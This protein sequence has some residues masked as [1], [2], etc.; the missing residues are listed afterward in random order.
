M[1]LI[2][3]DVLKDGSIAAY[4]QTVSDSVKFEKIKFKFPKS[5]S[6]YT[7]TAVFKN[8]DI[9][10]NVVLDESSMLCTG[11]NECYVPHEVIKYPYF[12]VSVFGI[13]DD[14]IAT[15]ARAIIN[16]FKS[17]YELGDAPSEPT[18]TEY[19]QVI[20]IC[21]ETKNIAE[22][23][24]NDADSGIFKGEKGDTGPQGIQGIQGEKGDQGIPGPAGPQGEKGEPFTYEDFTEEQLNNLKGEK[25]DKGDKGDTGEISLDY[26]HENF[27][28]AI[29]NTVKDSSITVNDVSPMLHDLKVKVFRKNLSYIEAF[30]NCTVVNGTV[31]QTEAD[32]TPNP[33][34][35]VLKYNDDA[36]IDVIKNNI[37]LS[38][39][40]LNVQIIK[41]SGFN[42]IIF[43]INGKVSDT[44]VKMNVSDL[45]D[46]EYVLSFNVTNITQGSISWQDVQLEAGTV[47]TE[48]TPYIEDL[49]TVM[50]TVKNESGENHSA[51][52]E[53]SGEVK[54]L[55][56]ISPLME[57][58][59]N[60]E[61]VIIDLKYNADTK[62]YI[63]NKIKE[64]MQG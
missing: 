42:H 18:P 2:N 57:L 60:N 19:Q 1:V 22:S 32:T 10:V 45:S 62:S 40:V 11:E 26:A 50:V 29:V 48:Y 16:V 3:A 34:F 54:G 52:A 20:N 47:A 31:T 12:T 5:W 13:K 49:C 33:V 7:K 63:D 36:Y 9:T 41:D 23:V 43:G 51:Y 15:S 46:G 17:G 44:L 27:A 14:S 38:L 28:S 61:G 24:R 56:S 6:E 21:E 59:A 39:G 30:K 53:A 37:A 4:Q 35:K 55:K 64:L 25:G 58:S 8:E